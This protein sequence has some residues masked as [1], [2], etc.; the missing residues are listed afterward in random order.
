[1]PHRSPTKKRE[2]HEGRYD[3]NALF[4]ARSLDYQAS[5]YLKHVTR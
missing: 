1:L 5:R 4:L 3:H 2:W